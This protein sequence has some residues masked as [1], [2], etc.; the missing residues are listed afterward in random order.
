MEKVRWSQLTKIEQANFGDGCTFVPDF[1]FTK[2]CNAHDFYY[3]IG[4]GANHWYENLWK[5]PYHKIS[6]DLR[7]GYYGICDALRLRH[8]FWSPLFVLIIIVY[9]IGL[10][11]LS[12]PYFT[13]GAWRSLGQVLKTDQDK[14]DRSTKRT[15]RSAFQP[16]YCRL[17]R[18]VLQSRNDRD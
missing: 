6:E 2:T 1:I 14:K 10:I 9:T 5:A 4:C 8:L 12:W 16:L 13:Y 7:M 3:S 17:Q 11:P 18:L 15:C